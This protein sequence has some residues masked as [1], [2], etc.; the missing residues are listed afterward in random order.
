M[1]VGIITRNP[2]SQVGGVE[3]FTRSLADWLRSEGIEVEVFDRT[4]LTG[5]LRAKGQPGKVAELLQIRGLHRLVRRARRC[6]LYLGN[7]LAALAARRDV[8]AVMVFHG[9]LRGYFDSLCNLTPRW[10]LLLNRTWFTCWEKRAARGAHAVAVSEEEAGIL[11][12]DYRIGEVS[13]IEN[14]IDTEYFRPRA[15]PAARRELGLPENA[16]LGLYAARLDDPRKRG[17]IVLEIAR[18]LGSDEGIIMAV[19]STSST[20]AWPPQVHPF[21]DVTY[22]RMPLLLSA[23][24]CLLLPSTFEGCSYS[25]I[26]GMACGLPPVISLT[27]HAESIASFHPALQRCI[28]QPA[29]P[30]AVLR[31]FRALKQDRRWHEAASRESRRYV[32]SHNSLEVMGRKYVALFER[33]LGCTRSYVRAA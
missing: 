10:R 28:V 13:T 3:R 23:A 20:T 19:P 15:K 31:V 11:R 30:Q 21:C 7:S 26:E 33:M 27:G 25:V 17:D 4:R 22:E 24:D 32:Q 2:P 29:G 18:R 16:F 5:R 6:D 8:P 1:R 14:G 12:R 9:C